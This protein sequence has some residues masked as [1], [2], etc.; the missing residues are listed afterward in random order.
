MKNYEIEVD[1]QV[2]HVKVRELPDDADMSASAG[3]EKAV[4]ENKT[5]SK[6]PSDSGTQIKSP[7]SGSILQVL[8]KPGQSVKA[9]DNLL[10]LE[11]MKMENE[12]V[13][14]ED[15]TVKEVLVKAN[16]NVESDQILLV[17]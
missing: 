13:A 4:D 3:T 16:D 5:T 17:F 1:G 9:G 14:P 12:I 8:V 15:G 6:S 7:M 2:Y 10:I 11:A